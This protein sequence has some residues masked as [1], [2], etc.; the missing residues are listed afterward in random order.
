MDTLFTIHKHLTSHGI[1]D[2]F[3][4]LQEKLM[5]NVYNNIYCHVAHLKLGAFRSQIS[6]TCESSENLKLNNLFLKALERERE[7]EIERI[8]LR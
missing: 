6:H 4:S 3:H 2:K 7:G 8:L 1:R 5:Q